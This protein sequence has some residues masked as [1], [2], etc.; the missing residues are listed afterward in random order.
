M[1]PR[2]QCKG[3]DDALVMAELALAAQDPDMIHDLRI[4]N[5]RQKNNYLMLSGA[6]SSLSSSRTLV[7][8]DDRRHGEK[9]VHITHFDI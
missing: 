5:D 9:V 2:E 3:K 1:L 8:V 7:R 4:L 6:Q